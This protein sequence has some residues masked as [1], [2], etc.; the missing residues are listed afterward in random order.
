MTRRSALLTFAAAAAARAQ[1]RPS[2][3][4]PAIVRQ[5]DA[6][7]ESYLER[8]NLDP[9]SRWRGAIPDATGLHNPGSASGILARGVAAYFHPESKFYRDAILRRRIELAAGHLLRVQ[10]SD[11]NFDLLT[12]NF[13]S[14]PDTSFIMLNLGPA[15]Q[16]ARMNS[17]AEMFGWMEPV[18]RRSGEGMVKGGVHTPNHRWVMCAALAIVNEIFPDR[19]Y[20]ARVDQWLAE[21]IDIDSDAQYSEQSTSVYNA[22]VDNAL[23]TVAHKLDK[24]E[25]LEHVRRN[26]ES[27]MHLMH[28]GYEVVTEISHRQDRNTT[29]NMGR[30]WLA[31]RYLARK[32]GDGRF[33]TLVNA[34]EPRYASLANLMTWDILREPGPRPA[35]IPDNYEKSFPNT[36]LSHIR[37]GKT[38]ASVIL[39]GNSRF[40]ALRRGEAVINGVRFAA[41]FFGK[42]QFIPDAGE[43]VGDVYRMTQY[44]EGPYFQP[45]DPSRKQPWGVVPW[46]AMRERR[47]GREQ[48]E[49]AKLQYTAEVRELPNGFDLHIRA[50]GT[51]WVPLAV[52]INLRPGG[53]VRGVKPAPD[54]DQAYLLADGQ[55]VYRMGADE[56]RFGPGVAETGY[57]QVRGALP[58]LPGPSVYLT[59][60]TP[61]DRT[62]EFRW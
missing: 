56:I 50:A 6:A 52:E 54:S 3:I 15:A 2:G 19:R 4:D 62:I 25:L 53:E 59:A 5:N 20:V 39:E 57:T 32:D 16:I 49:V 38:S 60:Y 28:P 44:L 24:P 55:A 27:M 33:E 29:A 23:V 14:P 30:Y 35:R 51:D 8:Q 48:T 13:N 21:T 26:L 40:F 10:S 11:G 46:Y 31:L 45:F 43:K 18:V 1:S 9:D 12:T 37:R 61:F 47:P 41:A 17:D 36:H 7:V 22:V 42:A 58:K 34:F